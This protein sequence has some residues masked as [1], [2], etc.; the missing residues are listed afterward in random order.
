MTGKVAARIRL[1]RQVD[2]LVKPTSRLDHAGF[3]LIELLIVISV[4]SIIA[5]LAVPSLTG[6]KMA[7]NETVAITY[8]RSWTAA[9]ENYFLR[10]GV[11]A[12]ADNQ[13]FNEGLIHGKA[14][15][16]SHGY[17]FA[18]DNPPGSTTTW[19]GTGW[20]DNP[21]VTGRRFFFIDSTGVIRYS[22][23][24]QANAGSTPLGQ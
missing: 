24:G 3:S 11:Y 7:A 8:M 1:M 23:S 5:A 4:I 15:A 12:D 2:T 17:T 9:Q 18:I 22:T 10:Y 13:L 14:P 16:D 6:S 19:W 20:P 21:G